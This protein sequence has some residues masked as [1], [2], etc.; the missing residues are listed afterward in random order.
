L[1]QRAIRASLSRLAT[2]QPNPESAGLDTKSSLEIARIINTEDLKVAV[3]VERVLPEIAAAIDW[4]AAAFR[5]GGRL[6]YV[7]SGTS[8]RLGAL[9]SVECPPTFNADPRLVQYVIA[10]GVRALGRAAEA[11]EDSRPAGEREIARK[12]PGKNDVVVGLAAS[13]R[14][15]FTLASLDYARRRGARTIAITCNRDTPIETIADLAIVVEV[16]PEVVSGST[17]MKAGTAQK[18]VL[19][20]LTTGAFTRI[21]Y[22][23]GNLMVNV[24]PANSKLLERGVRILQEATGVHR[25]RAQ[26]TLKAAGSVQTALVMLK[27]G[28]TRTQAERALKAADGDVRS[29]I[30]GALS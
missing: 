14:T 1:K 3:A 13:G 30:A 2:E 19:N 6:I 24:R 28:L 4:I 27:A 26:K 22:V 10:G 9:D 23:Y 16:G 21:G 17:R 15:P 29:A 11:D 7:G 20:M 5:R 8:G 18:M 25:A 12:R